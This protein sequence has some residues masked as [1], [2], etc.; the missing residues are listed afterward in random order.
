MGKIIDVS[1]KNKKHLACC[2]TIVNLLND[3]SEMK[4]SLKNL[5]QD[6][7]KARGVPANVNVVLNAKISDIDKKYN[8]LKQK[9]EICGC[10]N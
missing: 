1:I 4:D 3:M 5:Q 9:A 7:G 8:D 10:I 2:G 6:I